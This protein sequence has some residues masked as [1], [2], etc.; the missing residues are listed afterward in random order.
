MFLSGSSVN[1]LTERFFFGSGNQFI[2]GSQGN[3]KIF[4]AGNTTLSGS[5][6]TIE[7]PKFS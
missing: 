6:V 1:L 4:S 7:T 5:S 3:L 2:S